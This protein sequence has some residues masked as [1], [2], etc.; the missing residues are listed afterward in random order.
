MPGEKTN[1]TRLL[2]RKKIPYIPR[3]FDVSGGVPDAVTA[4]ARLGIPPETCYKTL[5]AAAPGGRIYVFVIPG[6]AQLDL[7]A[8]ARAAGEKSVEMLR[9]AL[10][11]SATGYVHGGCS[12]IGMKKR[13]PTFL[14]ESARSLS[15]LTVSAGRPGFH[16]TL[17]PGD[18]AALTGAGFAP[19]IKRPGP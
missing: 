8:A 1:V 19:V 15:R 16:V 10:L 3:A 18:L 4:A 14:D 11:L 7:K 12:P 6:P 2:D 17:S 13:F 5:V 9:Q